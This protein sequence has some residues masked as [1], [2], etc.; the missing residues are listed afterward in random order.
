MLYGLCSLSMSLGRRQAK[1]DMQGHG[2]RVRVLLPI[3]LVGL[4][5]ATPKD[6][7]ARR[8]RQTEAERAGS[9]HVELASSRA[10]AKAAAREAMLAAERIQSAAKLRAIE[11]RV[12]DAARQVDEAATAEK[13]E[14]DE[15]AKR[16]ESLSSM[17]P[18]AL[19]LSIYPSEV[20]LAAPAPPD[21]AVEGLLATQGVSAE[22]ARQ[23]GAL[24]TEQEKARQLA[25]SVASRRSA[26]DA[27]RARQA[28]A[29]SLLDRQIT[30]ADQ[31][32]ANALDQAAVAA[33]A[34]SVL[35]AQADDLRS[36]IAAMDA[37]ERRAAEQAARA[38]Q[39]EQA[40]RHQRLADSARAR[41]AVLNRPAGPGLSGA[42]PS[43]TL[44][45]G[46][47]TRGWGSPSEDGPSTGLTYSV[48]SGAFVV[49]PC[50]GRVAFAAPFRSYGRLM[51]IECGAGYDF[52]LAGMDRLDAPVGRGV[53]AG[54]PVGRMAQGSMA[55]QNSPLLYVELRK[56]GQAINPLPYLNGKP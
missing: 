38:A 4:G 22:L 31:A 18:L 39:A 53:R 50:A 49:S 13:A 24:R 41:Q 14:E 43:V 10:A 54:E 28:R 32:Q 30:Q 16:S 33:Q 8:L 7:A 19:R 11:Q 35:A 5:A 17:L 37:A 52:V 36:A 51:I 1:M 34:A 20:L 27:E 47:I 46:H 42:T 12:Q 44:V 40:Q 26:L 25:A 15:V 2:W 3:M 29:A 55:A 6:E 23:V 45:A 9:V 21:K 48:T 56:N